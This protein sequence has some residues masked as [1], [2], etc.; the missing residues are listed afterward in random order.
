MMNAD[1]SDRTRVFTQSFLA[2]MQPTF[3]P[4]GNQIAFLDNGDN[5]KTIGVYSGIEA[6]VDISECTSVPPPPGRQTKRRGTNG[7]LIPGIYGPHTPD[8]S[9]DGNHLIYV[10]WDSDLEVYAIFRVPTNGSGGCTMLYASNDDVTPISPQYSPDGTK[11]AVYLVEGSGNPSTAI[12]KLRII[13]AA[14]G[15]TIAD[16][17]PPGFF[18]EPVGRRTERRSRIRSGSTIRSRMRK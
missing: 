14:T 17:T 8:Y 2:P 18:G 16:H 13:N 4:T 15:A 6:N 10:Q 5:L 3:S 12:R 7:E 1:G 11:I 9:P